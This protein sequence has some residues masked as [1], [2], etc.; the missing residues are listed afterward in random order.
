ML[1]QATTTQES[2]GPTQAALALQM[3]SITNDLAMVLGEESIALTKGK[4]AEVEAFAKKKADLFSVYESCMQTIAALGKDK[5][6]IEEA[7]RKALH[8]ATYNFKT[9]LERNQSILKSQLKISQGLM[10]TVGAEVNRQQN[11]MKTY[12]NPGSAKRPNAPTSL[13]LN[14]TI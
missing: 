6:D 3:L 5:L 10:H 4:T 11:P 12:S 9:A 7:L 13:A 8:E 14:Q 2:K 1:A